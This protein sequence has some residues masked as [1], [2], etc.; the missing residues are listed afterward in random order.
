MFVAAMLSS[1]QEFVHLALT[2]A[3]LPACGSW[4]L[5]ASLSVRL[6]TIAQNLDHVI[7]Q[8]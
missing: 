3:S 5:L 8:R 6:L 4:L 7:A 2:S 1:M